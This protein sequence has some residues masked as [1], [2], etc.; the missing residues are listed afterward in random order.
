VSWAQPDYYEE[1]KRIDERYSER[2]RER[3]Q[4]V[5][6]AATSG[7]T[8]VA[9]MATAAIQDAR[10]GADDISIRAAQFF[11][12]ILAVSILRYVI[13]GIR[14]LS[15]AIVDDA[16]RRYE[17]E[18]REPRLDQTERRG[19]R[20]KARERHE[21]L[22]TRR[23]GRAVL[24]RLPRRGES[25]RQA[26]ALG[27][28]VAA[29]PAAWF[30]LSSS[31]DLWLDAAVVALTVPCAA[32]WVRLITVGAKH[33]VWVDPVCGELVRLPSVHEPPRFWWRHL[34]SSRDAIETCL[35]EWGDD[36][37]SRPT[38][39]PWWPRESC[40]LYGVAE[41]AGGSAAAEGDARS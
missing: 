4:H 7:A 22:L 38:P 11:L 32:A 5:R 30:A 20:R 26:V 3:E 2:S 41:R 12:T 6:M 31:R 39:A 1:A 24:A 36:A 10:V 14:R 23:L 15:E 17:F 29:V 13:A 19:A 28:S 35:R 27:T 25:Q 9:L 40:D 21:G 16:A 37:P 33:W 8:Y 34:L 18:L